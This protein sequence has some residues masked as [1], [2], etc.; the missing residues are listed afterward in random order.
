MYSLAQVS[1][2][3]L[4]SV[5]SGNIGFGLGPRLNAAGMLD[6]AMAAFELL[7]STDVFSAG[8]LAQHLDAQNVQRK[9]L[10]LHVQEQ[11]IQLAMQADPDS[12]VIFAASRI[13][14]KACG[15]GSFARGRAALPP[16]HHWRAERDQQLWLPAAPSRSLTS[17]SALD[18]CSDLLVRYG[19]IPCGRA[20]GQP[21]KCAE[22]LARLN[23]IAREALQGVEMVPVLGMTGNPAGAYAPGVCTAG[24]RGDGEAGT[25][26]ARTPKRSFA[27]GVCAWRAPEWLGTG[28][29]SS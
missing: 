17:P 5:N 19:G 9:D 25:T 27:A 29:I 16:G 22:L 24:V 1:G 7:T 3:K 2:I 15:S 21:G 6:S 13:L 11:A 10:T 28:S 20:D 23:A 18:K 26:D 8:M 4:E 14:M 12:P